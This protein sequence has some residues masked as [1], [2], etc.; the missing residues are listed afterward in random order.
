MNT[1]R[2]EHLKTILSQV[3][4]D[5]FDLGLWIKGA[6]E[7]GKEFSQL[8]GD[9]GTS[10]CA[11]GWA[12]TDPEFNKQGLSYELDFDDMD[13]F[14]PV[15]KVQ[16][17]PYFEGRCGFDAVG[18]FFDI[19]HGVAN[20]LFIEDDYADNHE[21]EKVTTDMVINRIDIVLHNPD[22]VPFQLDRIEREELETNEVIDDA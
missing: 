9:C 12:C 1:E 5:K 19:S 7:D 20:W 21:S 11:V 15:E 10:A 17:R 16:G 14:T 2:L 8:I 4:K 18:L 22:S 6:K 13:E 3:P